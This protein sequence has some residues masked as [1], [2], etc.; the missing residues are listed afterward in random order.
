RW[1]STRTPPDVLGGKIIP[2]WGER[3]NNAWVVVESNNHG[4]TTLAT[5]IKTDYP[6]EK[7]FKRK[8][9]DT[10]RP[11]RGI[12][13][14]GYATTSRTRPLAI[15]RLRRLLA[16]VEERSV[17]EGIIGSQV[18][19]VEAFIIHDELTY[20]ELMSFVETE[21]GRMEA[22]AEAHDDFVMSL[23]MMAAGWRRGELDADEIESAAERKVEAERRA[24][25]GGIIS[26]DHIFN[27]PRKR[28]EARPPLISR[29]L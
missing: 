13:D 29:T 11:E 21:M 9:P 26:L 17:A 18:R 6:R 7:I 14:L 4:L 27:L 20:R 24:G 28:Y 3:F 5:M 8:S 25:M 19:K 2:E 12:I 1:H 16:G 10:S 23:V 15:G 22:Q